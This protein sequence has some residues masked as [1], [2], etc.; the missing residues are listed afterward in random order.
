MET[1]VDVRVEGEADK[2]ARLEEFLGAVARHDSET[3]A[4]MAAAAGLNTEHLD[5]HLA[6]DDFW[7]LEEHA[8]S[9]GQLHASYVC[10]SQGMD[11]LH[12]LLIVAN[13]FGVSRAMAH[14]T[15]DEDPD[16]DGDIFAQL[17]AGKAVLYR[18]PHEDDEPWPAPV[19]KPLRVLDVRSL[20]ALEPAYDRETINEVIHMLTDESARRTAIAAAVIKGIAVAV[21]FTLVTALLF[22]GLWL[23]LSIGAVLLVVLPLR[24][25]YALIQL[26]EARREA[27][28]LMPGV[29]A[30][31]KDTFHKA[32]ME[33]ALANR[34][35]GDRD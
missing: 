25:A 19:G 5:G 12:L 31:Y 8:F 22:Q 29:P 18:A 14:F 35:K 2:L 13:A 15:H 17:S 26:H 1:Y 33:A 10:G 21:V 23:W 4:A 32:M 27:D 16:D 7:G 6:R 3:V 28:E 20:D 24:N 11:Q 30:H 34:K 9:N